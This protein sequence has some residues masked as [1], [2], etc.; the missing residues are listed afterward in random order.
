ML[1]LKV[2]ISVMKRGLTLVELSI[3]LVIIGLLVGGILAAQSMISTAK[4]QKLVRDLSQ[5]EI[6]TN[7]FKLN[8]NYYP[9]MTHILFRPATEIINFIMVQRV[10]A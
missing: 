4:L 10:Q 8:Y 1:K 9:E 5:Y 2:N 7:N 6:A 3:V